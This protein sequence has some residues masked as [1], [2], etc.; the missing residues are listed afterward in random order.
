[1]PPAQYGYRQRPH[2]IV[3]D[4]GRLTHSRG[5]CVRFQS[6]VP[7]SRMHPV[8]GDARALRSLLD[9]NSVAR[10]RRPLII[11]FSPVYVWWTCCVRT[12]HETIPD[13]STGLVTSSPAGNSTPLQ[14]DDRRHLTPSRA[15]LSRPPVVMSDPREQRVRTRRQTPPHSTISVHHGRHSWLSRITLQLAAHAMFVLHV[16]CCDD[17]FRLRPGHW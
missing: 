2:V 1:M 8:H 9:D 5:S 12:V 4:A 13:C 10:D 7:H 6:A 11:H 17:V 15:R 16:A 3:S 14:P